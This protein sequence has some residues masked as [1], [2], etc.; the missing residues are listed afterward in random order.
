[1]PTPGNLSAEQFPIRATIESQDGSGGS[2]A[3]AASGDGTDTTAFYDNPHPHSLN[4]VV[5][6]KLDWLPRADAIP[7]RLEPN[8]SCGSFTPLSAGLYQEYYK[9]LSSGPCGAG[10]NTT[11]AV[12]IEWE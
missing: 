1:M 4:V 11:Y 7:A 10:S 12:R 8:G 2:K 6:A 5:E 9:D 3:Y